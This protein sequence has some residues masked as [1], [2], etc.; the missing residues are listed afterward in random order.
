MDET[1]AP[2]APT[3]HGLDG[4]W[5]GMGMGMGPLELP[6]LNIEFLHDIV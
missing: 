2:K 4:I 1:P 6:E 5:W 3:D